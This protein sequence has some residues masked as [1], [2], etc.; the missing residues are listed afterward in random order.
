MQLIT[1]AQVQTLLSQQ[2]GA[3]QAALREAFVQ[4]AQGQAAV[5]GRSRAATSG[6]DGAALMVSAMGAVLP[7]TLWL[8]VSADR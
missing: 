6:T 4:L 2:P 1:E 7:R 8:D 3:A 5:L